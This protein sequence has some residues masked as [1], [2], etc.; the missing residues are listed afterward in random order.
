VV[1]REVTLGG[2]ATTPA[3]RDLALRIARDTGAVANVVDR[4]QLPGAP[5]AAGPPPAAASMPNAERAAAAA[6]ALKSNA[7]LSGFDLQ[8]R[9]ESGR[10]VLRGQVRTAAEKDLAGLIAREAAGVPVE[11]AVEVRLEPAKDGA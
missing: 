7:N 2:T 9:D 1:R 10:L 4:I 11:N 8:V 5:A 3:Q 6:R